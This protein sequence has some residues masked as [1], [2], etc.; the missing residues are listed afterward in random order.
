M[1]GWRAHRARL[2]G[3]AALT[4]AIGGFVIA[5]LVA[6][7]APLAIGLHTYAVQ[8]GSMTPTIDTGDLVIT[9]TIRP[10]EASIGDIVMFKDPEGT[11]K[12]ISHR[13]RAV[14]QRDGRSYFA[15]RGDANTGFEH[16]NVPDSGTIGEIVYRVPK[17]GF[18]LGRIGSTPGRI[19]LVVIPALL[20][21][22]LGLLRIWRPSTYQEEP[23]V[24]EGART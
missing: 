22:G 14:R 18:L 10:T 11:D 7:V 5:L 2:L 13:V 12:L 23:A 16:W 20:L 19:G 9:R 3:V 6:A 24:P 1:L 8:S 15:T 21:L 4:W 17:L